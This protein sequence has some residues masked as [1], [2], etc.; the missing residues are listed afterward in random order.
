MK[1]PRNPLTPGLK[2]LLLGVFSLFHDAFQLF[3]L[4]KYHIAPQL[5]L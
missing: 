4:V 2:L 5:I 3:Y 1:R